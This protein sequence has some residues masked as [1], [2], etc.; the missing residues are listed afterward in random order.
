MLIPAIYAARSPLTLGSWFRSV[1]LAAMGCLIPIIGAIIYFWHE[2]VLWTAYDVHIRYT[3]LAYADLG[4]S[5]IPRISDTILQLV[6]QPI[7]FALPFVV[8]GILSLWRKDKYLAAMLTWWFVAS[9]LNVIVQGK[10]W[11]YEWIPTFAPFAV[12]T[13]IGLGSVPDEAGMRSTRSPSG[14]RS[15]L[16][17]SFVIALAAVAV[18]VGIAAWQPVRKVAKWDSSQGDKEIWRYA[19]ARTVGTAGS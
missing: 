18:A 11:L 13:G 10:P 8:A 19:G 4:G 7:A 15:R 14:S 2:G 12:L 5:W 3:A 16:D 17:Q 1:G 6:G 9:V